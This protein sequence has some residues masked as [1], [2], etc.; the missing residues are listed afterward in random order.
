VWYRF[1]NISRIMDCVTCEKCRVWGKLQILGIGTAIKI[2][3]HPAADHL[4]TP[5]ATVAT[6][7]AQ[8]GL[9]ATSCDVLEPKRSTRISLTRQEIIALMNTLNNFGNSLLF[10]AEAAD[11]AQRQDV[12]QQEVVFGASWACAGLGAAEMGPCILRT[13]WKLWTIVAMG[14]LAPSLLLVAMCVRARG[15]K[16]GVGYSQYM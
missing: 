5:T 1:R 8:L 7:D 15:G 14:Y 12:S 2:L 3:L 16:G 4:I 11:V 13:Q 10:A 9:D 6:N